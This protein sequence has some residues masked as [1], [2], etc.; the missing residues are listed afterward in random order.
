MNHDFYAFFVKDFCVYKDKTSAVTKRA[1][2]ERGGSFTIRLRK[3]F[4]FFF[5]FVFDV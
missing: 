3:C 1:L 2:D 4:F 5:F